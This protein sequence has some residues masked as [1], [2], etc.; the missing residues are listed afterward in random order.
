MATKSPSDGPW[1]PSEVTRVIDKRDTSTSPLL[2]MTDVGK[3]FVKTLGNPEGPDALVSEWIGTKLAAWLGLPTFDVAIVDYPEKLAFD[4]TKGCETVAGPA[5]AARFVHGRAWD[6]TEDDLDCIANGEAISGLVVFD[7]WTRNYDRYAEPNR[8]MLRNVF[9]SEEDA[10][11]GRYR[12]LAM[13][14][15][16]CFRTGRPFSDRSLFAIDAVRDLR[17]YGLFPAF[18]TRIARKDVRRWI[19]RL[20]RFNEQD[21]DDAAKGIP[22]AWALRRETRE[23]LKTFCVDRAKFLVQA[24]EKILEETCGWHPVLPGTESR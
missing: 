3:A 1:V 14:H 7:M 17:T 23:A 24:A 19:D 22:S 2:V 4:L 20:A 13:D 10:R 8:C 21:F 9:L 5:F 11:K 6:G 16:E 12:L 18:R 15:T